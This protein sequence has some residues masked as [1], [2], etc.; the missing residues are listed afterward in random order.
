M[1][2]DSGTPVMIPSGAIPT[3]L[4]TFIDGP[5]NTFAMMQLAQGAVGLSTAMVTLN[6]ALA[7]SA[8][9]GRAADDIGAEGPGRPPCLAS[10]RGAAPREPIRL[11][12]DWSAEGLH[13]WLGM[14]ASQLASLQSITAQLQRWLSTQGLKLLSMSC[15]GRVVVEQTDRQMNSDALEAEIE[16]ADVHAVP[17]QTMPTLK[18]SP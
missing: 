3:S 6:G 1:P 17:V 14:D 4:K 12:A 8:A 7:R 16:R 13:L 11:H 2:G 9:Q 10:S 18:E 5:R 15:N